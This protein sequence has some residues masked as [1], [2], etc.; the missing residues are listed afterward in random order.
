MVSQI[1][2]L[3]EVETKKEDLVSHCFKMGKFLYSIHRKERCESNFVYFT[4]AITST[5]LHARLH[6]SYR[7]AIIT[8]YS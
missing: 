1:P 8:C 2:T 6:V 3:E 5:A 7:K 4:S